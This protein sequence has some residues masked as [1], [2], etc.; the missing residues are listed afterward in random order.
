M[1]ILFFVESGLGVG[2]LLTQQA[3]ELHKQ[4]KNLFIA[5]SNL[6][7]EEG[8]IKKIKD[9]DIPYLTLDGMEYHKF[10]LKHSHL[11]ADYINSN[12][13]NIV[14]V[15]TNW[16]LA[17]IEY[18]KLTKKINHKIKIIYTIHAYRNNY[19]YRKIFAKI[20]ITLELKLF[21]DRVICTTDYMI[22]EFKFIKNKISKIY[23]GIDN[24]FFSNVEKVNVNSLQLVYAAR[25][26]NGKNQDLLIKA[27]TEYC[28]KNGDTSSCL[29]LPGSGETLEDMKKL[30][31]NLKMT[32]QVKFYGQLS[33]DKIKELYNKCNIG[34][35]YSSSETFG[36]CIVEPFVMGRCVIST[37][38][39]IAEEIIRN[40]ETGFIFNNTED[41]LNI[42]QE[43]GSNKE[44][45]NV[46]SKNSANLKNEF[47]WNSV[48]QKYLKML[49]EL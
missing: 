1:N 37:K 28:K 44:M 29:H 17:L 18:L 43:I 16:E 46:I 42:L 7:Q 2:S 49:E 4:F 30:V 3:L 36:Q 26:R 40:G 11:L 20:L 10:F 45:I 12:Q 14:H 23:L 5:G 9:D 38:V 21:A 31:D 15:Q 32:N 8:L 6:E 22:N 39:G 33:V 41:L 47:T 25:F 13:I 34:I 48:T 24:R 27:F 35:I 19:K